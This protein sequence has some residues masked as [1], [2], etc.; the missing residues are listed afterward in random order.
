MAYLAEHIGAVLSPSDLRWK[1]DCNL[2]K[3]GICIAICDTNMHEFVLVGELRDE[4]SLEYLLHGRLL[5]C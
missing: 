4:D 1:S 3:Q 5:G 2:T